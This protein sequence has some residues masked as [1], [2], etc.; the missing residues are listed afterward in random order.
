MGVKSR[1]LSHATMKGT[2]KKKKKRARTSSETRRVREKGRIRGKGS[3]GRR[4]MKRRATAARRKVG[5]GK[6]RQ[7]PTREA[8]ARIKRPGVAT[9]GD[10]SRVPAGPQGEFEPEGRGAPPPLP[11]PIATFNI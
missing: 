11:T 4:A 2:K 8:A 6:G 7:S 3:G 9:N 5:P 1:V 10:A